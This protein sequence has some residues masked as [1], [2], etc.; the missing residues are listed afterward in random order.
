MIYTICLIE[1]NQRDYEKIMETLV[2]FQTRKQNELDIVLTGIKVWETKLEDVEEEIRKCNPNI[3]IL[4]HDLRWGDK[5]SFNG[6]KLVDRLGES[7]NPFPYLI[8]SSGVMHKV[9]VSKEMISLTSDNNI[10]RSASTII[11][12]DYFIDLDERRKCFIQ[13]QEALDETAKLFPQIRLNVFPYPENW[14]VTADLRAAANHN[15][16]CHKSIIGFNILAI[17]IDYNDLLIFSLDSTRTSIEI[18]IIAENHHF[19]VN[20]MKNKLR[21]SSIVGLEYNKKGVFYNPKYINF[22]KFRRANGKPYCSDDPDK[23]ANYCSNTCFDEDVWYKFI[24]SLRKL[25]MYTEEQYDKDREDPNM[26][27]ENPFYKKFRS[28]TG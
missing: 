16:H 14:I 25:N 10:T 23:V 2:V 15:N 12:K 6:L 24:D 13:L 1:D 22:V 7:I 3:I 26:R 19:G 28:F 9:E 4:D 21:D 27:F 20:D 17:L 11:Y 5:V 18:Q 8:S